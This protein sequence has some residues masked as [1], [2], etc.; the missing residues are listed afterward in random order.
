MSCRNCDGR[1]PPRITVTLTMSIDFHDIPWDIVVK[2][3]MLWMMKFK[4]AMEHH[5]DFGPYVK[6]SVDII[7]DE[8][9]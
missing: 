9:I 2:D 4:D 3:P 1:Y 6:V 7:A 5:P 8:A